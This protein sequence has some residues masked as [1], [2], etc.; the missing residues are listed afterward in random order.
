MRG[1]SATIADVARAERRLTQVVG[2]L[3][4]LVGLVLLASP[5][6]VYTSREVAIHTREKDY[7]VARQK[8]L[9]IP[10]ALSLVVVAAG[11]VIIVF[12]ARSRRA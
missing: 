3:L 7:K 2:I 1:R 9:A 4:I 6:V 12:A 11:I 5:R 8:V 10:P